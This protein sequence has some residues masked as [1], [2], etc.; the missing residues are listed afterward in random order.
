MSNS[1][2][3]PALPLGLACAVLLA[4]ETLRTPHV[5][6]RERFEA[7]EFVPPALF[8]AAA[9]PATTR[10]EFRVAPAASRAWLTGR[11]E[12]GTRH[13]SALL[14]SGR[15][16]VEPDDAGLAIDLNFAASERRD[17]VEWPAVGQVTLRAGSS[18]CGTTSVPGTRLCTLRGR[19]GVGGHSHE[20]AFEVTWMRLPGGKLRLQGV[21]SF[22]EVPGT[23]G[24]FALPWRTVTP[25]ADFAFDLEFELGSETR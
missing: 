5:D 8:L 6:P 16:T 25:R 24:G 23:E 12:L 19:W 21:L 15:M 4:R 10:Q 11:D 9:R 22:D 3:L 20:G 14:P 18:V 7:R 2:W 13:E 17:L 1:A